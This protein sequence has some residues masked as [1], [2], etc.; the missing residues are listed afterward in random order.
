MADIKLPQYDDRQK[1]A[2]DLAMAASAYKYNND[3]G[4]PLIDTAGPDDKNLPDWTLKIFALLLSL[5]TNVQAIY[6]KSGLKFQEP[7]PVRDIPKLIQVLKNGDNPIDYFTPDLGF[8][9]SIQD[10]R[11]K[12]VSDYVDKIF[13]DRDKD[14]RGS[15]P[16]PEIA[17]VW[18]SDKTFAYNFLA[19]P[20]PNQL[21]RYRLEARPAD[22]DITSID[23]GSLPEFG[24]D[25][26]ARAI[27]E[28]R[29]YLVDRSDLRAI[30]GNLPNAPAPNAAP[31]VFKSE[32]AG[33]WKYIYAPYVAFAVPPG[34][35]HMLPIAIQCGPKSEGFQ[36]YTPRDGYTWKMARVCMLAAHNNHHEVISHLGLTHLLMDPICMATRLRLHSSH[37]IYKLLS[38]HFEGTAAINISARTSLILPERSVDRLVGSKIERDYPYLAGQ[39]LGYSFRANFPKLRMTSRGT[40]NSVLLPNYPYRDDSA[41]I[42]DAIH[43]WVSD[44]VSVWYT[45]EADIRADYELQA[46]ANEVN[47]IGKVKDFCLT[48]GGVQGRDDLI[49]MLTMTIFTAG[50]QH[51]AVNFPQGKEM[52]FVP[53]NPLAGY[54]QAPKGLGH[55]EGDLLGILPPLDVAVQTWSILSLL[56]GVHNTNL[57]DYRGA[58]TFHP[59]SEFYRLKFIANLVLTEGNI[60]SANSYRRSIYEL[61]YVHLLP[62]RIP[63]SIN[64]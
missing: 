18:D 27:S 48:G 42:W 12:A 3:I 34:G 43:N 22:F 19:G 14:N 54:A 24:G 61:D 32:I 60:N 37:P 7:K 64:I 55:T 23:L 35:K 8:V 56:A 16:L 40:D 58:F 45:S 2:T 62:S 6:D 20:N 25:S 4:L 53:A 1:R 41:L 9:S 39:R 44:Y 28:G 36:I 51:A 15:A 57:G 46:W 29:V 5:R 49:D 26:M 30:F 63:A 13:V 17:T 47:D 50:P 10:N 59:K 38:P 52:L 21:E 11:A 31:R 33:E